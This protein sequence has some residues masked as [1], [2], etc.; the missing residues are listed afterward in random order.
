VVAT[1]LSD[2]VLRLISGWFRSNLEICQGISSGCR[3]A[4]RRTEVIEGIDTLRFELTDDVRRRAQSTIPQDIADQLWVAANSSAIRA[5]DFTVWTTPNYDKLVKFEMPLRSSR[6]I[7]EP[8]SDVPD[9][10][11]VDTHGVM[12]LRHND[13]KSTSILNKSVLPTIHIHEL[14]MPLDSVPSPL[15]LLT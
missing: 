7:S 9:G 2:P 15:T 11:V 13:P 12:F 4:F 6:N 3:R 8:V 5:F 10:T 14:I 1:D